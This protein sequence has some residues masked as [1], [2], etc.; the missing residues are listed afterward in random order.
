MNILFVGLPGSGKRIQGKLITEELGYKPIV[1]IDIIK[2]EIKSGSDLGIELD[3]IVNSGN[4]ISDRTINNLINKHLHELGFED[5]PNGYV[6]D[7]YPRTIEQAEEL[8]RMFRI[9][10]SRID[11]VL[12]LE[13]DETVLMERT[14]RTGDT[15]DREDDQHEDVILR[16]IRNY[17]KR[18]EPLKKYYN[19]RIHIID[20]NKTIK[21]VN[22]SIMDVIHQEISKKHFV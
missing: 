18:T 7:G 10:N 8:D 9:Y 16:R 19:D 17:D 1:S 3:D 21:D 20:G 14:L 13:V 6:F 12:F 4:L 22:K 2:K 15:S 11:V 5:N